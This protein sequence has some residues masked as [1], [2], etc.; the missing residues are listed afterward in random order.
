[1]KNNKLMIALSLCGL[2][3]LAMLNVQAQT[4]GTP[5]GNTAFFSTNA[6]GRLL[7]HNE[8]G[9]FGS[10]STSSQWIGI[11]QPTVS[12]GSIVKVPAYG[13]RSQW[14]GQAGIFALKSAS[15]TVKDLAV[16]W[17]SNS[18]SKLKFNF[19]T[20]LNNPSA[21]KEIM[22]ITP[23]GNGGV[24]I[25][26]SSPF[27]TLDIKTTQ[28]LGGSTTYGINNSTSGSN[29]GFFGSSNVVNISSSYYVYGVTGNVTTGSSAYT[30]GGYMRASTGSSTGIG[31]YGLYSTVSAPSGA[32]NVWAGYFQ[33][34]VYI[35]GALTV[36]SDKKFK[37]N[38]KSLSSSSVSAKLMELNPTSYLY[39][40]SDELRF[41]EGTQYGFVAQELEA[42]FPDLVKDVAQP[43]YKGLDDAG[44]P[45]IVEGETLRFKSI[46]YIGL[47]PVLTKALQEQQASITTYK[48]ELEAQ[49]LINAEQLAVNNE[50]REKLDEVLRILELDDDSSSLDSPEA[51]ETSLGQNQPN[52]FGQATEIT[53]TLSKSV[54]QANI[55]IFNMDGKL[56]GDY[57]LEK[58]ANAIQLRAN[59]YQPGVYIYVMMA[60]GE[61]IGT[62]RMIVSQ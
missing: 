43:V 1:M 28:S 30:Y 50:L 39:K 61:T 32:S 10:F 44:N 59:E 4:V 12:T 19:I 5:N 25:G 21:L 16:E 49:K 38:I 37:K 47:I 2:M 34:N 60:D 56:M 35:S 31:T 15:G 18:S 42:V 62:R 29:Y 36:A 11:G 51:T 3:L 33:G 46:N 52:P 13:M 14:Q 41:A 17:G 6:F 40:N 45:K 20:D 58:D 26:T 55:Q 7:G 48:D 24:G 57:P 9:T 8:S 22:T 23:A 53:Y 27:A 54:R